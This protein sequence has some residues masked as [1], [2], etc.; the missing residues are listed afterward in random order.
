MS[1]QLICS[2]IIRSAQHNIKRPNILLTR[3]HLSFHR[4]QALSSPPAVL[5]VPQ[6]ARSIDPW[7]S[8]SF[9]HVT[10]LRQSVGLSDGKASNIR[11]AAA[12]D[13]A[14][15]RSARV[16]WVRSRSESA[17]HRHDSQWC[18]SQPD[19]HPDQETVPRSADWRRAESGGQPSSRPPFARA[20]PVASG[21]A[22]RVLAQTSRLPLP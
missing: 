2:V 19:A 10:L 4:R 6:P 18:P 15:G 20:D 9:L 11:T 12:A 14:T 21:G 7:L 1:R 3:S 17:R 13:D 22:L 5:V 8:S 16:Q